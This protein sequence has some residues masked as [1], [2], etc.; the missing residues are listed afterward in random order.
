M[1]FV[2]AGLDILLSV[3]WHEF[4]VFLCVSKMLIF[5][6]KLEMVRVVREGGTDN[7]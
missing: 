1:I 4:E 5:K 6:R 3:L 2:L 7:A